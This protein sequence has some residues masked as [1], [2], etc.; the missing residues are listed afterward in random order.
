MKKIKRL[1][2]IIGAILLIALYIITLICAITDS[3]NT[4]QMFS[5]SVFATFVIPVLIWA[6]SFI[7]RILKNHD[8]SSAED[9]KDAD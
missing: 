7:Y 9:K 3:S 5:A 6:Y 2:A 1:L 4:M 8:D